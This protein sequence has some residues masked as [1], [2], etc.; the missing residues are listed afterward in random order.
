[1]EIAVRMLEL[2]R[3]PRNSGRVRMPLARYLGSR[4]RAEII[5]ATTA[6]TS[7]A[8]ELRLNA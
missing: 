2:K 6:V 4:I 8:I 5:I 7:H 3:A 1:M